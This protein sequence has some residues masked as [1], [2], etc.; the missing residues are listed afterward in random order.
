MLL[1]NF[2]IILY[3]IV[4]LHENVCGEINNK[5][6]SK[7]RPEDKIENEKVHVGS[8]WLV[9][10]ILYFS[11]SGFARVLGTSACCASSFDLL[12]LFEFRPSMRPDRRHFQ[13]GSSDRYP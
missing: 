3:F 8:G 11:P 5:A 9:M 6:Q 2:Y 10:F 13:S 4:T 1:V 12:G 7:D